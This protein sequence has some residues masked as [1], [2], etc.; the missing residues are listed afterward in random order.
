MRFAITRHV[1][2]FAALLLMP[3]T[4]AAQE[5]QP[6]DK[7]GSGVVTLTVSG[8]RAVLSNIVSKRFS[9]TGD[10]KEFAGEALRDLAPES[11]RIYLEYGVTSAASR[12]YSGVR[13]EVFEAKNQAGAFGLFSFFSRA[14]AAGLTSHDLGSGSV[15]VNGELVFWKANYFVRLSTAKHSL[16]RS[17]ED[18]LARLIA[19]AIVPTTA[20][21]PYPAL[22][23]SLPKNSIVAGTERYFVGPEALSSE[24]EHAREMFE[25]D[26]DTEAALAEYTQGAQPETQGTKSTA[27]PAGSSSALKLVIGEYHTP[28]FAT[29]AMERLTNYVSSLPESEQSAIIV[30]RTG[31]YVIAALNVRNRDFAESLV[32][33]IE[34]PYT[35]KWLR[36]PLWPTNDPFRTQKAAEML[37]STFG[38]LG[39]ILLTVLAGGTVFGTTIFLKR[40]KQQRE[41]FS[42][43]GGMLRLDLD[44]FES[45]L[46][47]LP[48]KRE[49]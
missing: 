40:R 4:A 30:K 5:S 39:L 15:R 32:N 49:E 26:G 3:L 44:P 12:E 33:S 8:P 48:P 1:L 45:A 31:N 38:L 16:G 29:D 20:R 19:D 42:D 18:S 9:E 10:I 11:S 46:L 13:V 47:G 36:N 21:V 14:A 28:Q 27:N 17:S 34:Y 6:A 37:L 22:L 35:V 7:E 25:F 2:L 24:I 41:I 23:E 43:A